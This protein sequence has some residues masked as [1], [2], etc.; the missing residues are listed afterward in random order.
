MTT[1]LV[2]VS[3]THVPQRARALPEQ[4]WQ[5]IDEADVVIHA[6]DW[7]GVCLLYTSPS[8]RDS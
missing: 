6:G 5:A 4:L 1:R 8:P 2:I 3:D 7:N